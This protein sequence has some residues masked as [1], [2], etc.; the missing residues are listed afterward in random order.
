M[1]RSRPLSG[2]RAVKNRPR[3]SLAGDTVTTHLRTP[4]SGRH[5]HDLSEAKPG[6]D[7]QSRL[8]RG[9]ARAAD[10][11]TTHP[12]PSSGSRRSH[13]SPKATLAELS[14]PG[15]L[16]LFPPLA[17]TAPCSTC[18]GLHPPNALQSASR[19]NS[20]S[21]RPAPRACLPMSPPSHVNPTHEVWLITSLNNDLYIH[22]CHPA[23]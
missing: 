12:R 18:R 20:R 2:G 8:I 11:V 17:L 14:A 15:L 10:A 1:T 7:R 22:K 4:S 19:C 21:R 6:R 3:P 9:Q 13:D 16:H 23:G 5:N